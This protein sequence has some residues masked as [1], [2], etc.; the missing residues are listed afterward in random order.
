MVLHFE[1]N[2]SIN[3]NKLRQR[4]EK[5]S[6]WNLSESKNQLSI[7]ICLIRYLCEPNHNSPVIIR[8]S[9]CD[10]LHVNH[11]LNHMISYDTSPNCSISL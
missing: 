6:V 9:A 5:K 4:I 7:I 10:V 3:D 11:V 8:L 1:S 2:I